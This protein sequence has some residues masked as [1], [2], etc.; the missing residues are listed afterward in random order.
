MSKQKNETEVLQAELKEAKAKL[1]ETEK[2]LVKREAELKYEEELHSNT[3]LRHLAIYNALAEQRK[4]LQDTLENQ[5][6]T[7]GN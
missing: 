4:V 3:K 7:Q 2:K 1:D 5:G 6:H